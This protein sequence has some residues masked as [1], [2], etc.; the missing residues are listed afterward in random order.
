MK[1]RRAGLQGKWAYVV[2]S[3]QEI[4]PSYE[5]AS[6]RISLFQDRRMRSE[7]VAFAVKKGDLVL[8][9][10]SG[11]GTMSK[12]V[13]RAGGEPVL[14][15]ASRAMLRASGFTNSVQGV[16]ER[17]PF[18]DGAFDAAVSGFAVR[19]AHDLET[20]AA[21]LGRVLKAGGR[22]AFCDLGKSDNPLQ[23]LALG[24]YIRVVPGVVGLASTGRS[25]LRYGSLFDT[26]NLVLHNS[27]LKA[28]LGRYLGETTIH[29]MQMGGAIVAKCVNGKSA[30]GAA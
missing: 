13:A 2:N 12:V 14:L 10:G 4:V 26:Y 23:A 5:D 28:L 16:F 20:A 25:G 17:L 19:D 6:S 7:A 24:L 8:D 29:E 11:P 3:L 30:A 27:E 18:R 9:L 15:D 22:F 21:E 1:T